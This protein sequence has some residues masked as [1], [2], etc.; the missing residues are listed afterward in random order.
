MDE[1]F[2]KS[3]YHF[4]REASGRIYQYIARTEQRKKLRSPELPAQNIIENDS[5]FPIEIRYP[6]HKRKE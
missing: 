2:K 3:V 1:N 6:V 4:F 5:V